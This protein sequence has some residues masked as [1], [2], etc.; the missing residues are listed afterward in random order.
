MARL[1]THPL[2]PD[3]DD[4]GYVAVRCGKDH[5]ALSD[6]IFLGRND[7]G[8][9]IG[10]NAQYSLPAIIA[11]MSARGEPGCGHLYRWKR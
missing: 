8:Q 10:C 5:S 3:Q 4:L 9:C 1:S 7:F 11:A 2:L 6:A